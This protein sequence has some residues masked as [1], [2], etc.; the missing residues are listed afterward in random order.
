[1]AVVGSDQEEFGAH[2][3]DITASGGDKCPA[4]TRIG[5][6]VR[7]AGPCTRVAPSAKSWDMDLRQQ[8]LQSSH[9][10]LKSRAYSGLCPVS[11]LVYRR[12]I[13]LPLQITPSRDQPS[14]QRNSFRLHAIHVKGLCSRR[15][16]TAIHLPI[17]WVIAPDS[18]TVAMSVPHFANF[19]VKRPWLR[20]WIQPLSNWYTNA[21]G[22]RQI[23]LRYESTILHRPSSMAPRR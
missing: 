21:A 16:H 20:A 15:I 2:A 10:I 12:I 18:P 1:M 11:F 3:G 22:Y 23:G 13:V 14:L 19:I 6:T 9:M 17:H 8:G 4:R 5:R 7:A